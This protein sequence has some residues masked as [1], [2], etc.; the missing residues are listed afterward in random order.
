[1]NKS[2][3]IAAAWLIALLCA[4]SAEAQSLP[5]ILS[6]SLNRPTFS[7]GDSLSLTLIN[8]NAI[9]GTGDLY[10]VAQSSSGALYAFDGSRW[11]LSFDGVNHV[12]GGLR[13]FRTNTAVTVSSETLLTAT[14]PSALAPP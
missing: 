4:A 1:M 9:P 11:R 13:A 14:L 2:A 6:L 7:A 10:V 5:R 8:T 3:G 12:P